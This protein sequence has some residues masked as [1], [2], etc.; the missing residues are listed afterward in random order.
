MHKTAEERLNVP[1]I[2]SLNAR[3]P[4]YIEQLA[5]VNILRQP[6]MI[7]TIG[8]LSQANLGRTLGPGQAGYDGAEERSAARTTKRFL[9]PYAPPNFWLNVDASEADPDADVQRP[10]PPA[11]P[12]VTE[13]RVFMNFAPLMQTLTITRSDDPE[14]IPRMMNARHVGTTAIAQLSANLRVTAVDSDQSPLLASMGVFGTRWETDFDYVSATE[15]EASLGMIYDRIGTE[16]ARKH[17]N[18]ARH[19]PVS[20]PPVR[21]RLLG[22]FQQWRERTQNIAPRPIHYPLDDLRHIITQQT[23]SEVRRRNGRMHMYE[24]VRARLFN[25]DYAE[26]LAFRTDGPPLP[27]GHGDDDGGGDGNDDGDDDD[28]DDDADSDDDSEQPAFD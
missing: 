12:P 5:E 28:D 11:P 3:S 20:F 6:L 17:L 13:S 1:E 15:R 25:L 2:N 4:D 7:A 16:I 22:L 9:V 27:A 14:H 21:N 18:I 26:L 19:E 23:H 10:W 24:D 8:A